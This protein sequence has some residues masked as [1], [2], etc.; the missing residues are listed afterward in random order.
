M[1]TRPRSHGETV[2]VS[3]RIIGTAEHGLERPG[4]ERGGEHGRCGVDLSHQLNNTRW[5]DGEEVPWL[6][7]LRLK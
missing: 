3:N 2:Q 7:P 6:E 5:V 4:Q 1:I